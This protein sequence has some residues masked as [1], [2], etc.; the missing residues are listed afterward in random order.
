MPARVFH[1]VQ[2]GFLNIM[3][4]CHHIQKLEYLHAPTPYTFKGK[5]IAHLIQKMVPQ[6]VHSPACFA[7]RRMAPGVG[8]E[9][10]TSA[11]KAE[12]S[13]A[14]LPR[15]SMSLMPIMPT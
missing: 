7:S 2:S 8:F 9:P 6:M 4:G 10:A 12:R 5:T 3:S 13:T 1:Y 15:N 11:S 14:E